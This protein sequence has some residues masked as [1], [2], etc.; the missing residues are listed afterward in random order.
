MLYHFHWLDDICNY[1]HNMDMY[2]DLNRRKRKSF[3]E[4]FLD[5]SD[6]RLICIYYFFAIPEI[7]LVLHT[8][9]EYKYVM[10][11]EELNMFA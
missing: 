3:H 2:Y 7:L 6:T 10:L 9:Y 11:E 1:Q 4:C 8:N 5:G